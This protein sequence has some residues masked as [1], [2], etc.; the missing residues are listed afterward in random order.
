M[1]S[2]NQAK[3]KL[4]KNLYLKLFQAKTYIIVLQYMNFVTPQDPF[5]ALASSRTVGDTLFK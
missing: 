3:T 1:H 5:K 2:N 4:N